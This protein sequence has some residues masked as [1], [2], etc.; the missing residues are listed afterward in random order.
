MAQR[1][2]R[3]YYEEFARFFEQPTREGLRDLLK[4]NVGEFAYCDFKENWP[5][6]SKTACHILG[7]ANSG[8]GCMV[9]G[10]R[11]KK[12]K[13]LESTGLKTLTDKTVVLNG[14]QK[15]L[16]DLL[17]STLSDRI[18]VFS[19]EASEYPAIKGKKFQ[20]LFVEDDPKHIPFIATANGEG[21]RK[22]G[23]YVRRGSATEEANHEELQRII[24]RRLETGYSSQR[25]T[26]LRTHLGQLQALYHH[27]SK[28]HYPHAITTQAIASIL[29]P[30]KGQPELNPAYPEEAYED[31][32]ARMIEKKKRLI[33]MVLNVQEL[34]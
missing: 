28:Y 23:M 29:S 9:I 4:K 10:V 26:D 34:S 13:S 19:F 18:L 16:P 3:F 2:K 14:I 6:H 11:Q 31:F 32:V 30:L 7:I 21:I 15:F 22:P 12:D 1:G 25:E 20:V 27:I 8:G 24:N 5:V 33:E 17:F